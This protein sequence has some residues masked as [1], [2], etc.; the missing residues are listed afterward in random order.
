MNKKILV[1]M[2]RNDRAEDFIPFIEKV[3]RPGT[4]VIFMLSYP[5]EGLRLSLEEFG[6][7]AIEEGKRLAGYYTW[8]NNLQRAKDRISAA[9][10]V[11]PARGIEVAVDL[12]TGNMRSTVQDYTAKGDVHLILTRAGVGN[13]IERLLDSTMSVFRSFKRPSFSPVLLINPRTLV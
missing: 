10:K 3:A 8:D 13:C 7:K 1:P 11:L 2:K 9:W 5:A 6:R 12:Y 4:T